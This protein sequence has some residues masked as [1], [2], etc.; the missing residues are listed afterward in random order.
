MNPEHPAEHTTDSASVDDAPA[1]TAFAR[2][3]SYL[4]SQIKT[5]PLKP[6][7]YRMFNEAGESL[8]VGKAKQ[9]ARRVASYTQRK[10]RPAKLTLPSAANLD[11][12]LCRSSSS[13]QKRISANRS[14][15]RIAR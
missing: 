10:N 6:G 8:Y 1:E 7:V 11:Q 9:L 12:D 3:R 13:D 15:K 4:L 2:G 5:L 14:P